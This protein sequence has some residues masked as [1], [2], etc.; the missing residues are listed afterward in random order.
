MMCQE[1]ESNF[2]NMTPGSKSDPKIGFLKTILDTHSEACFGSF[3]R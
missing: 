2:S 1:K 3:K